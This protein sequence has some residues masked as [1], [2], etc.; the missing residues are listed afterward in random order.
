MF[1]ILFA[2]LLCASPARVLAA[3]PIESAFGIPLGGSP[4]G[5]QY[6]PNKHIPASPPGYI[7]AEVIPP[8]ANP[9]FL[10]YRVIADLDRKRIIAVSGRRAKEG[11]RS[12]CL[13]ELREIEGILVEKYGRNVIEEFDGP[14]PSFM[15]VDRTTGR[16]V[17]G[18][19]ELR[20]QRGGVPEHY[21]LRIDYN[22]IDSRLAYEN[23]RQAQA[24]K[25]NAT[26]L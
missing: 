23:A 14:G 17:Y 8:V 6:V 26:G 10:T 3:E 19:C 25:R 4:S 2:L 24:A 13:A 11:S 20:A 7:E 1:P 22:E 12:E 15:L 16:D 5:L 21:L 9:K 18:T